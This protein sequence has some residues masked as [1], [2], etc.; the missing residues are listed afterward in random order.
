MNFSSWSE[1]KM[2]S[3]TGG[4]VLFLP[5]AFLQ[6]KEDLKIALGKHSIKQTV[7]CAHIPFGSD[8]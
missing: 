5:S 8:F 7:S 2:L 4:K 6:R 1:K 3:Q